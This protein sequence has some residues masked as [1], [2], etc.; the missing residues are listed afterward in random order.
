MFLTSTFRLTFFDGSLRG[1]CSVKKS[2]SKCG[3]REHLKILPYDIMTL[4]P[5]F[6]NLPEALKVVYI[7][8]IDCH[9]KSAIC[10]FC[11]ILEKLALVECS[12]KA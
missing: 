2:Q 8:L 1:Q 12:E 9:S 4:A 11:G 10:H 3:S 5:N 6:C 7:K